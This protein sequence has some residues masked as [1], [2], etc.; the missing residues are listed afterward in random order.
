MKFSTRSPHP[1]S[2]AVDYKRWR[3]ARMA[4]VSGFS[5]STVQNAAKK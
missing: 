3:Q 1:K 2:G 4:A 5:I